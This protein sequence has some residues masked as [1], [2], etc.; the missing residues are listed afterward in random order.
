MIGGGRDSKNHIGTDT[1]CPC[2][3]RCRASLVSC[4]VVEEQG[5]E[6]KRKDVFFRTN[7]GGV[8]FQVLVL[9]KVQGE[10]FFVGINILKVLLSFFL[11]H[12]FF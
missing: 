8:S 3:R 2:C 12:L 9:R 7:R 1:E 4:R 11:N 6:Q 5:Y 10:G